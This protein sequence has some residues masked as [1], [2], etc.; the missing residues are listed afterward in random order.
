MN[1][2]IFSKQEL[3]KIAKNNGFEYEKEWWFIN[4]FDVQ[5][6]IEAGFIVYNKPRNRLDIR[7]K[8]KHYKKNE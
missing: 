6:I 4:M 8:S 3:A 1:L 2:V 7:L 5:R